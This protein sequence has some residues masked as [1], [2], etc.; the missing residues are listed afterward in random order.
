KSRLD[1]AVVPRMTRTTDARKH[2]WELLR[3]AG[4]DGLPSGG[5]FGSAL[6]MEFAAGACNAL[7]EYS[8][9][10]TPGHLALMQSGGRGRFAGV[11]MDVALADERPKV[12]R[13]YPESPAREA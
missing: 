3:Q 1:D 12:T 13:V 4:K 11:G 5:V 6:V 2:L 9:F 7:D 8:S 10:L